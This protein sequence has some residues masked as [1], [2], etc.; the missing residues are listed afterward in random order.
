[1]NLP[2]THRA[3]LPRSPLGGWCRRFAALS[4]ARTRAG[5]VARLRPLL[6]LRRATAAESSEKQWDR[7]LTLPRHCVSADSE[8]VARPTWLADQ[9]GP[10]RRSQPEEATPAV[11]T[12]F[13]SCTESTRPTQ[14][15][16]EDES[17]RGRHVPGIARVSIRNF[18]RSPYGTPRRAAR[19]TIPQKVAP[20]LP[21]DD[22]STTHLPCSHGG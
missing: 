21:V 9:V 1:M 18:G 8:T 7:T 17:A 12:A 3:G 20:R 13:R 14:A 11:A 2:L 16:L 5:W 22:L 4:S 6:T 10:P 19:F 15:V